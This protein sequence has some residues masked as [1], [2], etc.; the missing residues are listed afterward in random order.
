MAVATIG[1]TVWLGTGL[2]GC[3]GGRTNGPAP[4]VAQQSVTSPADVRRMPM[5]DRPGAIVSDAARANDPANTF[6]PSGATPSQQPPTPAGVSDEVKRA[7]RTPSDIE[8]EEAGLGTSAATV[9]SG[10]A[11]ANDAAGVGKGNYL[12]LGSIIV[13]VNGQPI[14]AGRILD[15]IA[16]VLAAKA[17]ELNE[18]RFRAV[19]A[20][21]VNGA[22]R[23]LIMDELEYAI[24][25]HNLDAQDKRLAEAMTMY[26]RQEMIRRAGGSLEL[27]RQAAAAQG[28]DF[29]DD[30]IKEQARINFV[31][32]YYQKYVLPKVQISADDIRR[33][34]QRHQNSL[35]TEQAGA[36]FRVI[37]IDF[38][39]TGSREKALAKAQ[40]IV[41]RIARGDD[42]ATIAGSMNDDSYLA[43]NQGD[44]TGGDGGWVER[45]SYA[46]QKV[47]D[48]VFALNAGEVTEPIEA[49]DA[50]YIAKLEQ[51]RAGRVRS[52]DEEAVQAK[53]Q[54][55]LRAEQLATLQKDAQQRL[56]KN[57]VLEPENPNIGPVVE[58][59]MQR[60]SSWSGKN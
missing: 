21:E 42:F 50:F 40:D 12:I 33:Y 36:K 23:K 51:K 19:A 41:A 1:A 48:A 6:A 59:A 2:L 24:A 14:T 7:V 49:G 53:I 9:P 38:K 35:F 30:V 4:L 16:P 28:R 45:G 54:E 11:R 47:E 57:A 32:V 29:D 22:L 34:Y 26:D 58:M 18:Q 3:G 8:V 46:H 55:N 39:R 44:V 25:Q 5:Q 15:S 17:R 37:K 10:N 56:M 52:F 20:E 13:T 43:K 31:R 27:A 60:Y